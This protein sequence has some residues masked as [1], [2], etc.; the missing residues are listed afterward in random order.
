[1]LDQTLGFFD[2]HFSHLHMA[3]GRLVERGADDF[4]LHGPLHVGNFFGPLVDEQHDQDD[5]R[6]IG[7]DGICDRLQQ[8]GL[9]GSGRSDDQPALA[10]ANWRKQIHHAAADALAHRLHAYPLLRIERRQVVE[11]DLVSGFFGRLEVDGLDLD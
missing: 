5:F 9:A 11:E 3:R 4:A 7:R 6:V 8:H 1:M 10:F 2:H